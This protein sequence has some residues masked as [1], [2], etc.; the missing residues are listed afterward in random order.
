LKISVITV[1]FNSARTV[2]DTLRSV[3]EQTHPEVEHIVID[4]GSTDQTLDIVRSH[5]KRVTTIVS[6]PDR[7]IYDAMNK[8]IALATGDLIGFLN[9]DDAYCEA[10]SL[11]RLAQAA[12]ATQADFVFGDLV[13]VRDGPGQLGN[14]IVRYWRAGELRPGN[15][16]WGWMPPH[17]TLYVRR[18]VFDQVGRFDDSFRIAADY[19]FI[20]RLLKSRRWRGAYVPSVI[21][22]MRLGGASNQSLKALRRKSS[23]DLLA[24]RR[25]GAGGIVT[26]AFK[27]LRKFPQLWQRPPAQGVLQ[28][29][30]SAQQR[31]PLRV[32]VVSQHFWP[33]SLRINDVAPALAE[34]G[35]EVVVLTGKPNYPDGNIF[36][37]YRAWGIRREQRERC[38]IVRVPLIPRGGGR[39]W[40]LTA[41]YLSFLACACVLGP[42]YLRRHRFDVVFVYGTSPILQALAGLTFKALRGVPVVT[43]VQD[44]WPES[45]AMTGYVTDKRLLGGVAAIVRWI[46]RRSD[47][48]LV[49]SEAFLDLIRRMARPTKVRYQPN[50]GERALT[51][52]H[53]GCKAPLTLTP[54][55]N[56][57][58][59]GNLGTVQ[60]L[61]TV[62]EAAALTADQPDMRWVLVGSG[63]R[64]AWL[65]EEVR[66]RGLH[67][68]ELPGRFDS[69]EM[70]SIFHQADALLVTLVGGPG[71]NLTIP[72]KIQAYLAVGKP[73]LASID[74]E[75]ARVI[76]EAG[77]GIV[78]PAEDAHRLA[79]AAIELRSLDPEQR[80]RM[81]E[82]GQ[83]YFHSRFDPQLVAT[84]LVGHFRSV[85][86]STREQV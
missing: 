26:L 84:Q 74:G 57:V 10:G 78:C 52:D 29:S 19:E 81:G 47:L 13:Y 35:C 64:L 16:R 14:E 5:G 44:L 86:R 56:I 21:V 49:Q 66:R 8:G 34:Q 20:L 67:N 9:S 73:I 28:T 39:A 38:E 37:G 41:N 71:M 32:L 85:A 24:L 65:R 54:G 70:P 50:P 31:V 60:A 3:T 58:F 4:G 45:L 33:E 40:E 77:A 42:I 1:T 15:L 62:V 18:T 55:F 36:Q 12:S 46:Y 68:I 82:A 11:A 75:G 83:A 72:S 6:E 76:R 63:T 69:T 2:A 23:E 48:V 59:A 7:G 22:K 61:E 80:A 53:E 79:H 51:S 25:H 43:W 30:E 17:P 27:N